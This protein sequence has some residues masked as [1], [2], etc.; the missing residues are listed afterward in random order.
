MDT[1]TDVINNLMLPDRITNDR[2]STHSPRNGGSGSRTKTIDPQSIKQ[3]PCQSGEKREISAV[4]YLK[5]TSYGCSIG[6]NRNNTMSSQCLHFR[7]AIMTG[8]A[9][10]LIAWECVA[11][12]KERHKARPSSH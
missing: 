5:T 9:K 3:V 2:E 7:T 11:V 6:V 4:T 12:A 8:L 1:S 10:L